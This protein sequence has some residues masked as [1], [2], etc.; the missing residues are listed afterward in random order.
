MQAKASALALKPAEGICACLKQGIGDL[1]KSTNF[2]NF[3]SKQSFKFS[4][5]IPIRVFDDYSETDL[6]PDN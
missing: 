5:A 3:H 2:L 4:H 1:T 6:C